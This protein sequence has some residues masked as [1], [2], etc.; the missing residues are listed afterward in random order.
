MI[1]KILPYLF[2]AFHILIISNC[3]KC[4]TDLLKKIPG[5]ISTLNTTNIKRRAEVE[6]YRK[7]KIKVDMEQI[8]HQN[9]LDVSNL[10][11]LEEIFNE[12]QDSFSKILSVQ[13]YLL[14]DDYSEI[15]KE[16]CGIEHLE[17]SSKKGFIENDLLIFPYLDSKKDYINDN[18]LA[19][20]TPCLISEE[21]FRPMAGLV[22]I[23]KDIMKM[24]SQKDYKFYMKNLLFHELTHVL[25]FHP[26]YFEP[27][28]LIYSE[29]IG[30]VQ[31]FYIKSPKVLEKAAIHF[32]CDSIKGIPLENQGG[33]GSF[34]SHWEA[35]YMLGDYMISTDYTEVVMSDITL[36]F[37]EDTGFY[38]VNYY[39]GGLFRFGKI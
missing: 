36:A 3:R 26:I 18:S 8:K 22:Y 39:T 32:G 13:H 6:L 35:R 7:I 27:L 33:N 37:L 31:N 20:A 21:T 2:I 15:F 34:G 17:E 10:K 23:N 9:I 30:N 24:T 38:K 28:Q 11:N 1:K 5:R 19:G 12:L 16:K 29:T 25:G 14:I 4:G